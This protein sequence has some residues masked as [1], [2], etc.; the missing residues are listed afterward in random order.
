MDRVDVFVTILIVLLPLVLAGGFA[1]DAVRARWLR[2]SLWTVSGA[3]AVLALLPWPSFLG[4]SH[5]IML[6]MFAVVAGVAAQLP[7]SRP[8]LRIR[9]AASGGLML[10]VAELGRFSIGFDERDRARLH[11]LWDEVIDSE[12]WSEGPLTERFEAAWSTWN[13]LD[14]VAFSGWTGAALAALEFAGVRGGTVLC[15]SNTFMATPLAAL[16]AGARGRVRRLQ[17]RGPVHV[18]RG[19]RGQGRAAPPARGDPRAHR[20]THRVRRRA[21]SR[22]SA[23]PRG[24]S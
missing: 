6:I 16:H 15:P 5:P 13:G 1:W 12:R 2:T 21:R 24:S 18:V 14:S 3:C 19:L 9:L 11:A 8:P 17:P 4:H 7:G 10:D 22:S 23:A 20:R